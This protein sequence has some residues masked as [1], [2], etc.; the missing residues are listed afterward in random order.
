MCSAI[1]APSPIPYTALHSTA[2]QGIGIYSGRREKA[3]Q[4]MDARV[5]IGIGVMCWRIEGLGAR[6]AA[7]VAR[8]RRVRRDVVDMDGLWLWWV[9]RSVV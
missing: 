2:S 4:S 8:V 6:I 7:G 3:P 9:R 1:I 5:K